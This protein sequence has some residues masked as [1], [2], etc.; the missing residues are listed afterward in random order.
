MQPSSFV[1][2]IRSGVA[3]AAMLLSVSLSDAANDEPGS[4]ALRNPSPI[5]TLSPDEEG[6]AYRAEHA[7]AMAQYRW[8]GEQGDTG[9]GYPVWSR[10]DPFETPFFWAAENGGAIRRVGE[11]VFRYTRATPLRDWYFDTIC[12][13][14]AW[15]LFGCDD[16]WERQMS[17][18]DLSTIVFDEVRHTRM[19]PPPDDAP[20]PAGEIDDTPL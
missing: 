9:H 6:L 15:P 7:V 3:A 13:A 12:Y 19:L 1:R 20:P 16:G 17:A 2:V 18:P 8:V 14:Q 4:P 10:Q 5:G 11:G